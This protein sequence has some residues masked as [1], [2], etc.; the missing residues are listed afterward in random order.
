M[1]RGVI[2]T[3]RGLF[4]FPL[5]LSGPDSHEQRIEKEKNPRGVHG[6][7]NIDARYY[8]AHK[9]TLTVQRVSWFSL[10]N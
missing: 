6:G 7:L 4:E 5:A 1:E 8:K 2:E 10:L 3:P 9:H